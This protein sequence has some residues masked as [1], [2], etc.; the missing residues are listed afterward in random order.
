MS[1]TEPGSEDGAPQPKPFEQEW[2]TFLNEL[3]TALPGV[4]LLFAFLIAV[5]FSDRFHEMR[6]S[7]RDVYLGCFFATAA[8]SAFLIAPSVYHRLHWRRNV[9][10]K[11]E[12]FRTCNRLAIVGEVLLAAAMTSAIFVISSFVTDNLTAWIAAAMS[13]VGLALLWFVLPTWRSLR[14]RARR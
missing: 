14:D 8:S 6:D 7:V 10:D 12:M 5:P 11:E 13:L 3:R 9:A 4:Q 1:P 2:G